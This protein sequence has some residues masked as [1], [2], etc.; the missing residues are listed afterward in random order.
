MTRQTAARASFAEL[1]TPKLVTVL[2]EGY[3]LTFFLTIF[4]GLTEAI[5]AGVALGPVLFIHRMSQATAVETDT[6]FGAA[7]SIASVLDR[8]QDTRKA[9]IIHVSAAPFLA[10]TGAHVM[11]GLASNTARRQPVRVGRETRHPPGAADPRRQATGGAVHGL[12]GRRLWPACRRERPCSVLFQ[13]KGE[14]MNCHSASQAAPDI[15]SQ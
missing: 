2:R 14:V 1:F 4:R 15:S 6:P 7:A 3:G 12:D 8:M 9:L 10:S 5:I 11:E 13:W